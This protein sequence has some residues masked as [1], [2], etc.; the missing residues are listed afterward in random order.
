MEENWHATVRQKTIYIV[1]GL[2]ADLLPASSQKPHSRL[3]LRPRPT[4]LQALLGRRDFVPGMT[5]FQNSVGSSGWKFLPRPM[6]SSL[7]S[8][9][10]LW[11]CVAY[12]ALRIVAYILTLR[13]LR[14]LRPLRP[15]RCVRCVRWMETALNNTTPTC[16]MQRCKHALS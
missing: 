16:N 4:A 11:S 13:T 1:L 2:E 14:A 10:R 7:F 15:L 5:R 12:V 8:E 9:L 3:D 6:Y